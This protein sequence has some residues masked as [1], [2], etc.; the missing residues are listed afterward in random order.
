MPPQKADE[1]KKGIYEQES[2]KLQDLRDSV[3]KGQK[4]MAMLEQFGELNRKTGTGGVDKILPDWMTM[5]GDKQQMLSIQSA[6][7]PTM[8]APGSGTFT[9][10][11]A[12]LAKSGLPNIQNTGEVNKAIRSRYAG[13]LQADQNELTFKERYLSQYGHLNGADEAYQAAQKSPAAQ[14]APATQQPVTITPNGKMLN[15][16]QRG[17]LDI[18][19]KSGNP[20]YIA[21]ARAK[22]WIQ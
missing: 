11:D 12:R 18:V 17:W 7:T 20:A 13:M 2:K 8:R 3:S 15:S 9:D 21:Q 5:D 19:I 1:F 4:T 10:A 16:Q 6:L 22:G 14:Q